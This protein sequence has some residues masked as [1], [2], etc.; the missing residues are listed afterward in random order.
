MKKVFSI[1]LTV[2]FGICLYCT[3]L[4][5]VVRSTV[6]ASS[7]TDFA[8]NAL[9]TVSKV[10]KIHNNGLFY[11]DEKQVILSGYDDFDFGDLNFSDLGDM[12]LNS[13]VKSYLKAYDVQVEPEFITEILESPETKEFVNKYIDEIVSYATGEKETLEIDADDVI[14]VV[15]NAIDIY[16]KETGETVDRTGL[17]E[18]IRDSVEEAVT[19]VAETI[20]SVRDNNE[21][22][23]LAIKMCQFFISVKFFAYCVGVCVLL[24]IVI[25]VINLNLFTW[26]KY[27]SIPSIVDGALMFLPGVTVGIVFPS[28]MK[29]FVR[30]FDLPGGIM[31]GLI[32]VVQKSMHFM[33]LEGAVCLLI[34]VA[35]CIF[36]FSLGKKT[37]VET[38]EA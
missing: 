8:R 14:T 26:F 24:A 11:P 32:A 15:N 30:E 19:E 2:I 36:G 6:N 31:D 23:F 37:K 27:I 25:F 22:V 28:L 4:L 35:L 13:I 20:D 1:I 10:Q 5:S 16:E 21:L 34:G 12:D 33:K 9:K 3:L 7:L 38:A 18:N 17:E 29:F